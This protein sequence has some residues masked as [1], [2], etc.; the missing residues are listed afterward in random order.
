MSDEAVIV[1]LLEEM[2]ESQ[3]TPED[4]CVGCPELLPEVRKRWE[5][6]QFVE[7]RVD[8]IFPS[9]EILTQNTQQ[10]RSGNQPPQIPGYEV[11]AFLGRGGMGV[12]YKARHLKLNR[13]VAVKM[14]LAGA[15]ADRQ[16]MSRFM[17]EAVTVAGLR[18]AHIV[19]VYD[20]GDLDGLP[21]FTMEFVGG[22]SL[23]HKL[24]GVPQPARQAAAQLATLAEAVHHAHQ[25]GIVH[26]D[27]KPSNILLTTDGT[28]KISDFGLARRVDGDP[29]LT[30]SGASVGTPSYMPPEQ[31]TGKSGA[32]GPLVDVY[33]LGAILYETL[34]GR[35][36][37]KA[38]TAADTVRQLIAE[39][40][41][42]PSRLNAKVPRD[43]ET[44]CLKCLHREPQ[45]RYA[46]AAA[47][48]D[49]LGRFQRGE[50][51]MARPAGLW[52][53]TV[54]LAQRRPTAAALL[55]VGTVALVLLSIGLVIYNRQLEETRQS[56][57]ATTLV[58]ALAIADTPDLPPILEDLEP[59]RHYADPLLAR[60]AADEPADSKA[61]LHASLALLPR[62]DRQVDYLLERLLVAS[63]QELL[64]IRT[65]LV[66]YRERVTDRL[67]GW[68]EK[69]NKDEGRRFRAACGLAA[70]DSDSPR[71]PT[72][73]PDV[74]ANL[75]AE[76]PLRVG[77][78][79]DLLRPARLR[80][81]DPLTKIALRRSTPEPGDADP[82]RRLTEFQQSALAISIL[83]DYASDHPQAL[84][85]LLVD[86]GPKAFEVLFPKFA[87]LG[88]QAA[89][90]LVPVIEQT[91]PAGT[92]DAD[93]DRLAQRKANAA[94]ALLRMGHADS[95]W[96]LLRH[97]ADPSHRSYLIHRFSKFGVDPNVLRHR[98]E[99]EDD[100]SARRALLLALGEFPESSVGAG[101]T[102]VSTVL[103]L[104]KTHPDP[105]L[106]AAAAWTMRQRGRGTELAEIDKKLSSRSQPKTKDQSSPNWWINSAGLSMVRIPGPVE[107]QMGSPES[108]PDR[109]D[110]EVLHSRRIGRSF[111]IAAHHVTVAQFKRF[112][113]TFTH[114]QLHRRAPE[115][116]CP[117][118]GV[119]WY[120]AAH[121][122]NWLSKQEGIPE[123]EW[124]Y[125]PNQQ[126]K[127]AEGMQLAPN[128][129]ERKG[130]RLPTEAEWEYCCRAGAATARCYG[131]SEELLPKYAWSLRNA[132]EHAW[133][134]GSLKPNDFGLFDM[135][136]NAWSWCSDSYLGYKPGSGAR[137]FLGERAS[138]GLAT[139]M[140]GAQGWPG[141]M[142]GVSGSMA[143]SE[144]TNKIET[145]SEDI[146]YHPLVME[147]PPRVMRGGSFLYPSG[148]LRS[149]NRNWVRP[150]YRNYNVGFRVAK[151]VA[152]EAM[153][154]DGDKPQ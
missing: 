11:Q 117:I 48:A 125:L 53:R 97:S 40:L 74:A 87:A 144:V 52:E 33:A 59:Y 136:G 108:E 128:Y 42:P 23:A 149:A 112:Y 93:F 114:G 34:T 54:K 137:S 73:A 107:F 24:A 67:W 64:V 103:E 56:T 62:D 60:I 13:T 15:Y 57:R 89:A 120:E 6:L 140:A 119:T 82:E 78:W 121:Y 127:Y 146:M 145:P 110:D 22:G 124:C 86:V 2:M 115:P 129:L 102:A 113:S 85:D 152:V 4:V 9:T 35:P 111:A 132:K 84:A 109:D 30:L 151:T 5:Q 45:R 20:V 63:P 66:P 88:D 19:Q 28:P 21:Y 139:V 43:L 51:I 95:A 147:G 134:V 135:H 71:W 39:E 100:L 138:L 58:Q 14:M 7:A 8:A 141:L 94:V 91:L 80:L 55:G 38:E 90:L 17:R 130:Y 69:D 76:S 3:A 36:P 44:I 154:S 150:S 122:C 72:V 104:Y 75:V 49:D 50:P 92:T 12:V 105:G 16:Q 116:D 133:P 61:R 47:L 18:H 79:T 81:L 10:V 65:G 25:S 126:G 41:V 131:R 1:Q 153:P 31:A 32:I 148:D 98:F 77:V 101:T 46:S 123:S 96:P 143:H 99:T 142:A 118:I 68:T 37:F 83:A 70:L 27:L 106:H 26:R 29:A